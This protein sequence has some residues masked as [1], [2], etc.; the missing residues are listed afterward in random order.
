MSDR[1]EE[2]LR[3]HTVDGLRE[4][5]N[6]MP[7]WWTRTFWA[8]FWFAILYVG[9]FHS[10]VGRDVVDEYDADMQAFYD[11]QTADLL[12]LG[13]VDEPMLGT[14]IKNKNAMSEALAQFTKVCATCHKADATGD[15]GPNLTDAHWLGGNTLMDL[16]TVIKDGRNKM[17]PWGK[18]LRPDVVMKLAAYV[19]TLRGTNL[20]GKAPEG[21]PL[22]VPPVPEAKRD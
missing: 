16:Y 2:N 5:D 14:F 7:A 22:A 17:P 6:P 8:T 21:K 19:G 15:I 3:E 9:Y 18:K 20:P 11:K 12:A 4:Y 13:E 1:E 10:K